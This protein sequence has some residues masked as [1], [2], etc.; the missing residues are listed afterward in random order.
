MDKQ[1]L[2]ETV[3]GDKRH[4]ERAVKKEIEVIRGILNR[5]ESDLENDKI[6]ADNGL[7]GNEWRLYKELSNL[8]R[9][10]EFIEQL[11]EIN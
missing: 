2:I 8:E 10:N 3:E 1:D 6:Y 7:Q 4:A 9:L 5:I 11:K